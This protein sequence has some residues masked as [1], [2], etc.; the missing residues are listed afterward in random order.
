MYFGDTVHEVAQNSHMAQIESPTLNDE[1]TLM[2]VSLRMGDIL[3]YC[4]KEGHVK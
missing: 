1:W 3:E 2:K 4:F